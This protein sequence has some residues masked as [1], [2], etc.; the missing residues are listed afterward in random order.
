MSTTRRGA[1]NSCSR[2]LP[3][4]CK[5]L[6][7]A[8]RMSGFQFVH[9]ESYARKSNA[10]GQSTAFV[11]AE[12]ARRPG[13][14]EHV[15]SPGSPVTVFGKSVDEVEA[16]H[17]A[18]VADATCTTKTGKRRRVRSDQHTLLTVVASHPAAPGQDAE[19]V[20]AWQERTVEWLRA[21][22]GDRLQSV[23]RHDDE[24][25]V[26]VHAYVLP[27][28]A[29]MRARIL[30]PGAAAKEEAKAFA[31]TAG[32]DPKAANAA[33]DTAYK[34]AMRGLQDRFF[35]AVGVP[36]GL[37][38]LGPGRRRLDRGAWRAEQAQVEHAAVVISAASEGHESVAEARHFQETALAAAVV[39]IQAA[40]AAEVRR[41]AAEVEE[42]GARRRAAGAVRQARKKASVIIQEARR[43]A[44]RL[45][46][47]GGWVGSLWSGFAGV[48]RRL[49]AR[50][51]QR[52]AAVQEQAWEL[53]RGTRAQAEAAVGAELVQ[54][55]RQVVTAR[56]RVGVAVS[57]V[58]QAEEARQ[59]AERQVAVEQAGRVSAEREREV[60]RG[61]WADADNRL[62]A[63]QRAHRR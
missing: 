33:G 13:A 45:R 59:A 30:H 41:K 25:H 14:C 47:V 56:A 32:A 36:S 4:S 26:H 62:L 39:A 44:D 48:Q 20:G 38:R 8:F 5:P 42:A 16:F 6:I 17:D 12:A 35:E 63:M 60:F 29:E 53:V 3:L 11:F 34:A 54:A 55:R 7:H 46:S 24:A 58:A 51:D 28:D 50:A 9:I 23:V 18:L 40:D 19:A 43:E 31:I 52:V 15:G 1:R 22:W 49:E 27:D 10:K 37:A 57:Q 21:E 61:R 2:S